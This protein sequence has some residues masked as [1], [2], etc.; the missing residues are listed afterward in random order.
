M[1]VTPAQ[2]KVTGGGRL[3]RTLMFAEEN[4]AAFDARLQTYIDEAVAKQE[5]IDLATQAEKDSATKS[6]AYYRAFDAQFIRMSSTPSSV[7]LNDQGGHAYLVTQIEN[8]KDLAA[9]AL[10]DFENE[11]EGEQ[12]EISDGWSS[13]QSLRH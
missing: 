11:T 3:E 8:F 13:I 12:P 1:A 2:L 4:D 10:E 5:V 9:A 7:N 6:W